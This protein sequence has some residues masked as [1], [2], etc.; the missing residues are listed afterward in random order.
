M[1][2]PFLDPLLSMFF[3]MLSGHE[4]ELLPSFFLKK[5]PLKI[6]QG[7]RAHTHNGSSC[8]VLDWGGRPEE[9]GGRIRFLFHKQ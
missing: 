6:K 2:S 9:K 7:G 1:P 5:K 8:A 3:A 4:T